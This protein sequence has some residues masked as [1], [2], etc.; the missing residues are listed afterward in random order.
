M[1][2]FF[3]L[4]LVAIFALLLSA[5]G[6]YKDKGYQQVSYYQDANRS[7]D[8]QEEIKNY[9]PFKIQPG[10]ILGINV[11]SLNPEAASVFNT[12][13]ARVSGNNLDNSTTNPIYGFKVDAN[14][15]MQ[16]PLVGTM[17]VYG[18]T[19]DEVAK[20]LTANL[21][22]YLKG[23]IVNVRILNFKIS[24]LGDVMK[25]DIYTIQ[26]EH[27]NINEALSLAGDLSI[28]AKRTNVLL[29]REENGKR[30]FITLDLTKKYVFDSPYYYLHNNDVIY[31]DADKTKYDNVARSYKTNTLVISGISV[32]AI[33]VSAFL[34][35]HH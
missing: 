27:I 25:P 35:Y 26:N 6:L 18:L 11:N 14:G 13:I 15:Q 28:T 7:G 16:L 3:P 34:V 32:V 10:D 5:C 31:V 2:N 21:Q 4:P 19:T 9:E 23:P 33:L 30:Q 22:E 24:V 12:S 1:K 8:I 29:I 17:K 20:Q